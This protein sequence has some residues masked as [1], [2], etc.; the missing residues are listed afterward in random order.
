MHKNPCK[1]T[2]K[3][4][5]LGERK[6]CQYS[7]GQVRQ[8]RKE[9]NRR[10]HEESLYMF[11]AYFPLTPFCFLLFYAFSTHPL[12]LL[13]LH[14]FFLHFFHTP[15]FPFPNCNQPFGM[16]RRVVASHS[17][18]LRFGVHS[19]AQ[20]CHSN[21]ILPKKFPPPP[22]FFRP[23]LLSSFRFLR[24]CSLFLLNSSFR[25]LFPVISSY[26]SQFFS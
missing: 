12:S 20:A 7:S 13:C 9:G 14:F 15:L 8:V 26:F 18:N 4:L 17:P 1:I 19:A 21:C 24:F 3:H 16:D 2:T 23:S 6:T 10:E 11:A 25:L 5:N 22:S